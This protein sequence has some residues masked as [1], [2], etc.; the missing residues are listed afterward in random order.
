M[1]I[2]E[3]IEKLTNYKEKYGDIEIVIINDNGLEDL[4]FID[5]GTSQ[6]NEKDI[7]LCLGWKEG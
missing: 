4:T 2:T 1:R 5:I 7:L 6:T 3:L